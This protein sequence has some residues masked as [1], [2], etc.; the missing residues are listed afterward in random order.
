MLDLQRDLEVRN[1]RVEQCGGGPGGRISFA[2]L[3]LD[4][5]PF[6]PSPPRLPPCPSDHPPS[7][8]QS[9]R[10]DAAAKEAELRAQIDRLRAEKRDLEARSGGV[11]LAK[12]K[13]GKEAH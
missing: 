5:C 12:I 11:D 2:S 4:A 9:T 7:P 6:C 13:V 1:D 8:L 10:E 3:F